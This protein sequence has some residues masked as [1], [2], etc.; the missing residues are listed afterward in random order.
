MGEKAVLMGCS[1][2]LRLLFE[3]KDFYTHDYFDLIDYI[4]DQSELAA[5]NA[6]GFTNMLQTGKVRADT[7]WR[8]VF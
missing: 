4:M 2:T 6:Y 1:T 5:R 7:T 3:C 8:G